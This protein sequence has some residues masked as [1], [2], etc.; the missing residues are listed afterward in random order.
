MIQTQNITKLKLLF[1]MVRLQGV[2]SVQSELGKNGAHYRQ[3][4]D[5]TPA[6]ND[7]IR[8]GDTVHK[9]HGVSSTHD[10]RSYGRQPQDRYLSHGLVGSLVFYL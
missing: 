6:A 8:H 7:R 3:T 2:S 10:C 9:D 1:F 5:K 4:A